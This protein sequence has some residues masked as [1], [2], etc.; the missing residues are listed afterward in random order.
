MAW[1]EIMSWKETKYEES[2]EGVVRYYEAKVRA[3]AKATLAVV[4][5][6]LES[7]WVRY[8]NDWTGRGVVMDTV[9]TATIEGLETVRAA[10]M[11]QL[12]KNNAA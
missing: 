11:E 7:Q 4:E 8:G 9:I 12:E 5:Q 10:C 1:H 6:E 3:D 2:F